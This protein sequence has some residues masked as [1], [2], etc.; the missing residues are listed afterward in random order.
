VIAAD[1][2]CDDLWRDD[3]GMCFIAELF[4]HLCVDI[5]DL[6]FPSVLK[7]EFGNFAGDVFREVKI[8][9]VNKV[10]RL[11]S[12]LGIGAIQILDAGA[13]NPFRF[14]RFEPGISGGSQSIS[15][16]LYL[17]IDQV[18][19]TGLDHQLLKLA[20]DINDN[21]PSYL[22]Y[23]T[24]RTLNVEGVLRK[25][26]NRL[27]LGRMSKIETDDTPNS[28]SYAAKNG[29]SEYGCKV[30]L[31][32]PLAPGEPTVDIPYTSAGAVLCGRPRNVRGPRSRKSRGRQSIR[33]QPEHLHI[34]DRRRPSHGICRYRP[35]N[36]IA[37]CA[38]TLS[39]DSI[40]E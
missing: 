7:G 38:P 8:A 33:R 10:A 23:Q 5:R 32:H 13:T 19:Q 17:L 22:V 11:L 25:G 26:S 1:G 28:P 21:M 35:M 24:I 15:V 6:E 39:R 12:E 2:S 4:D 9:F 34:L 3:D 31:Y 20:R 16:D 27:F 37:R 18:R 36:R 14:M 29:L 40:H 30:D